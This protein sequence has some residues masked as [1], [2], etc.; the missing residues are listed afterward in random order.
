LNGGYLTTLLEVKVRSAST[1]MCFKERKVVDPSSRLIKAMDG[2]KLNFD[3]QL[4]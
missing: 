3:F 1:N 4:V 2:K